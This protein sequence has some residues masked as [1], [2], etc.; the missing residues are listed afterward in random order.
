MTASAAVPPQSGG[1]AD[2]IVLKL[3]EQ[4]ID[5]YAI[6]DLDTMLATEITDE[7]AI[8]YPIVMTVLAACDLLGHLGGAD[9][10]RE[11]RT[12]FE[13]HLASVNHWYADVA[14]IAQN[15]VRNGIAHHYLAKYGITIFRGH[16][17]VHLHVNGEGADAQLYLDC[18]PLA[19]D[20]IRSYREH[21]RPALASNETVHRRAAA[22]FTGFVTAHRQ[23]TALRSDFPRVPPSWPGPEWDNS[24]TPLLVA[25]TAS[26][27]VQ[28][29]TATELPVNVHGYRLTP[30]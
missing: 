30:L 3:L 6:K 22:L 17:E 25:P 26:G 21:A 10:G 4:A 13:T 11:V 18:E 14:K 7:G 27:V 16:P 5:Q 20:F 12:Y 15:Q 1:N 28:G 24:G 23:V 8:G 2:D 19:R 9:K 29:G